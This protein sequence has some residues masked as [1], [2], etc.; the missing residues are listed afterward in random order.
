MERV[1]G[2]GHL[3]TC[4]FAVATKATILGTGRIPSLAQ[5]EHAGSV[6]EARH[7]ASSDIC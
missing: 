5:I 7:T 2:F 1:Q 6:K 3:V 4:L